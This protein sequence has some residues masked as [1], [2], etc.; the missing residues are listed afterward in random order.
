MR[1]DFTPTNSRIHYLKQMGFE[2]ELP[3]PLTAK[4]D[5]PAP[6]EYAS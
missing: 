5:S 6:R 4:I 3:V 1:R 2:F